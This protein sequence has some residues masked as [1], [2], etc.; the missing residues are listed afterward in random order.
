MLPG[1][2][3]G[4]RP[5]DRAGLHVPGSTRESTSPPVPARLPGSVARTISLGAEEGPDRPQTQREGASKALGPVVEAGP[6]ADSSPS[7]L[8]ARGRT[9]RRVF[10][11]TLQRGDRV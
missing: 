1:P 10:E 2:E 6:H 8:N 7:T 11:R 4:A 3:S 5:V 9:I